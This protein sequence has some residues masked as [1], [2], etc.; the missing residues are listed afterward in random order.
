VPQD[1]ALAHMWFNLASSSA[2]NTELRQMAVENR[3][4]VA[5]KMTVAQIAEAQ[6]MAREWKPKST[7][8]ATTSVPQGAAATQ[9]QPAKSSASSSQRWFMYTNMPAFGPECSDITAKY[10]NLTPAGI[11]E[12]AHSM[13]WNAQ[14]DDQGKF[15]VATMENPKDGEKFDFYYV[16]TEADC[17]KLLGVVGDTAPQGSDLDKYR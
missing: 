14:I 8:I 5:A 16:R 17:R 11:V 12:W 2:T 7:A 6:R 15:V 3:D 4:K 9:P 10:Q 13:G 1:Y